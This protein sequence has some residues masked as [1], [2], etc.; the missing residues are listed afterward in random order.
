MKR[1]QGRKRTSRR[2]L[3]QRIKSLEVDMVMANGRADDEE[4]RRKDL[5]KRLQTLGSRMDLKQ[6]DAITCVEVEPI[7]FGKYATVVPG[8]DMS[9][10]ID[11]MKSQLVREIA[12]SLIANNYVQIICHDGYGPFEGTIGAKLYVVPW[13]QTVIGK[14][15]KVM[16]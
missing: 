5:E 15:L 10:F 7:P 11:E 12:N 9:Q 4:R 13:E 14:K 3:I 6:T 2:E 16:T 1:K 8:L